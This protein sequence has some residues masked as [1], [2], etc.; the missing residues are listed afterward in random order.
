MEAKISCPYGMSADEP[1]ELLCEGAEL[2]RFEQ[3][4]AFME[5]QHAMLACVGVHDEDG[6]CAY[7]PAL[8]AEL[9]R[10][11]EQAYVL[12]PF[13]ERLVT[14]V[15]QTMR[16]Q[17]LE[18]GCMCMAPVARLLYMYTKVRGYKVVSRFFPHQVREMPLLLD[19][20]E[21]FESPTWECLY[22]LL[23]WLSSVVLVPF[24]L[25]RGT[26]S[27][28]ERIH[29]LCARFLSRPGKERDAASIVLGRLY[30]RQECEL[31]FSA[32]L[33]DAEQA[34]ASLVPTGVLQTLCAFVKQADA[35]LIRAHYDA[36]LRVIAH[37]RTVDTRNMLVD[38]YA[39][40]LEGRLAMHDPRDAHVDTLLHALA[41]ADSRVRYSAAKGT[42]RV[43]SRLPHAWRA[44]ILE[45]L[46][47]MLSEHILSH[48]MPDGLHEAR[49]FSEQT[50]ETLRCVDLHGVSEYTWHGVFLALAECIRRAAVP[51]DVRMVYW[52]LTG[53]VFDVRRATGSTGT[54]V[55]DA[56]CYVLWSLA[57][58]RDA[59]HVLAVP[60]AQRLIIAAT[61]DRDVAVRRAASAAFQ[62]WVG[63]ATVPHGIDIL[64][65][66]DFA[67]VG[68]RRHAYLTCAPFVAQFDTYRPGLVAYAERSLLSHWDAAVRILGAQALARM[69]AGRDA[70]PVLQR[71]CPR[72][73]SHDTDVAH[74][75]L[76]A[77]AH[78]VR[79]HPALAQE[80]CRAALSTSPSVWR[81][82][83]GASILASACHVVSLCLA[84]TDTAP[85]RSLWN[86]A[87]LR[88][89]VEVQDM[90]VASIRALKDHVI[91]HD[92]VRT[93]LDTW[94]SLS[95]DTQCVAAKAM[96]VVDVYADERCE[97]LC[98]VLRSGAVEARCAAA[99]SLSTLPTHRVVPA[100]R[101]GLHDMTTDARGD[102]G[103]WV[104]VACI[105]SLGA[106]ECDAD[107]LVDMAGLLMER[108]DTVRVKA[109]DVLSRMNASW[110]DA[111]G[112]PSLLRDASY[113][114]PHLMPLLD[115]PAYR[116]SLLR[117]LVRTIGSRSDMALRV[118][119]QALVQWAKQ[120][121]S[122]KVQDVGVMLHRQANTHARDNRTF[123]PVLQTVQ[124]LL[125]W[126]VRLDVPLLARFVRLASH[127]VDK[128]HSVP[129]ILAAMRICVHASQVPGAVPDAAAYL[130]PF[131]THRYPAVRIHTSEQL[132]LLVQELSMEHDTTEIEAALLDTPWATAPPTDLGAASTHIVHCIYDILAAKHRA[133]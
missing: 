113:A 28:S 71:L 35:S 128:V 96:G 70:R 1:D 58:T 5:K 127:H 75:A 12:D 9:Q 66:A 16:A 130:I 48:T 118:A 76:V 124:L 111:I 95:P 80:A 7:L 47:T 106:L 27:P 38:R 81:A 64:R 122:D 91:V 121:S 72:S 98:D 68:T 37:L 56:C 44:Q 88:P 19:A 132:F 49:A 26:P 21:R 89:E 15:A 31:F 79:D 102:V 60:I 131:L 108:I 85:L 65:T 50:A 36:M 83:G 53:L 41:H 10:Y 78:L 90:V 8:E 52:T 67:A 43:A 109:A 46:L 25:D 126:D 73:A 84:P 3:Y 117:S 86:E 92:L 57:R 23:L 32:F 45:A 97:R 24:P 11:Q 17:V 120:A 18:S 42:A 54:S 116:F 2:V 107:T 39:I 13:L 94:P 22:V 61:L 6:A 33:Q 74:G 63:R 55:R 69:L 51:I 34:T 115:E 93:W 77:L 99:R 82:P 133:P 119:G 129:R 87:V 100:L 104:R 29:R 59:P 4:D 123:V 105:E 125:D 101:A 62:E 110:R 40:K 20:L 114:F 103:S 112:D 14:P 30:A